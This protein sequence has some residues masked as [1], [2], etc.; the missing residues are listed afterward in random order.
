M[1]KQYMPHGHCFAYTP[2]ILWPTV[3]ADGG[4]GVYYM[5]IAWVFFQLSK[6]TYYVN[7]NYSNL[8]PPILML[9]S[10]FVFCCGI[11]HFIDLYNVWHGAYGISSIWG[12]ITLTASGFTAG[13]MLYL[14]KRII[15][16]VLFDRR[17]KG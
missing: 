15:T 7:H 9:V 2:E 16:G 10:I 3:I 14:K 1:I 12:L 5:I 13:V 17:N 8:I 6:E 4:I 11:G